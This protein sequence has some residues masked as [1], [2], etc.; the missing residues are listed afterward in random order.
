VDEL[1]R[2]TKTL[3][4]AAPSVAASTALLS[5]RHVVN[6]HPLFQ[7]KVPLMGGGILRS[8]ILPSVLV[9]CKDE[10]HLAPT[11]LALEAG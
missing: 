8:P 6:W 2:V 7:G 4:V 11:A 1:E 3:A 10:K 9:G 5:A